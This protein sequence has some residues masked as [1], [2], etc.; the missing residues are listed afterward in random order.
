MTL[1]RSYRRLG[2]GALFI[3]CLCLGPI[4]E[5]IA[6]APV[7][8]DLNGALTRARANSQQYQSAMQDTQIAR[9]EIKQARSGLLPKATVNNQ[10]IYSQSNGINGANE[11]RFIGANGV[12]E[13][14]NQGI[15]EENISQA[16]RL[17]VR[18]AIIGEA[19]SKAKEDVTRRGLATVVVQ[20]YYAVVGAQRRLANATQSLAEAKGF[21]ETTR[22]LEANGEVA[23]LD[24]RRAEN[25]PLQRQRD[26]DNARFEIEKAQ[27]ELAVLI[28]P[29]YDTPFT[30]KDDL[31]SQPPLTAAGNIHSEAVKT[32]PD[33]LA[34]TKTLQQQKLGVSIAKSEFMPSMSF[35]YI[36]GIDANRFAFH[37]D[38]RLNLG[39]SVQATLNIPVFNWGAT[40][41]RIRQAESR[42]KQAELDLDRTQKE[43]SAGVQLL[44]KEAQ[45]ARSQLDS[46]QASVDLAIDTERLTRLAYAAGEATANEVVEAQR[47]LTEARDAWDA[48]LARYQV[49]WS[50]IQVVTG[51]F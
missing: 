39:S 29:S 26:V 9:E 17:Q 19:I 25:L 36:Y 27:I 18:S 35:D 49:A 5:A 40:R 7:T 44:Y 45:F 50:N 21:L 23:R 51:V 22:K 11:A 24:V 30:V 32:S 15:V 3:L 13:F 4:A 43:L 12:H 37:T 16:A 20:N 34:A 6:Q 28:F 46:L 48:G 2:T 41:S 1:S 31:D 33:L 42:Q 10:Y 14:A 47:T 38:G 8:I